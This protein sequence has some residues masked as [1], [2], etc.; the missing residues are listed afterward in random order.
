MTLEEKKNK[1]IDLLQ[2]L[3]FH[4]KNCE[5]EIQNNIPKFNGALCKI[6]KQR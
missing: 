4:Y 1:Y 3:D 2:E 5:K 6:Y